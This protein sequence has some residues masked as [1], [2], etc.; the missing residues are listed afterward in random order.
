MVE[1]TSSHFFTPPRCYSETQHQGLKP[2]LVPISF[3]CGDFFGAA[4]HNTPSEIEQREFCDVILDYVTKSAALKKP[5][6][7]P[8]RSGNALCH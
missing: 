6:T 5:I 2:S 7:L 1:R 8:S 3:P 4:S